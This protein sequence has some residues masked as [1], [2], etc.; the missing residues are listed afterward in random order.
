MKIPKLLK[1]PVAA[2]VLIASV[3]W[4]LL[5]AAFTVIGL[6]GGRP[7]ERDSHEQKLGEPEFDP[8]TDAGHTEAMHPEVPKHYFE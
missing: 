4:I 2:V 6:M 5:K 3:A 1:I 8:L 7:D